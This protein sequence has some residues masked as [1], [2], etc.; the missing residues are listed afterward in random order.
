MPICIDCSFQLDFDG[1]WDELIKVANMLK[2][3]L[4]LFTSLLSIPFHGK[5]QATAETPKFSVEHIDVAMRRFVRA[6][7]PMGSVEQ[8]K[9]TQEIKAGLHRDGWD[10]QVVK[11][12][13]QI[14]NLA[15]ERFGGSDKKAALVKEAEGE[16]IIAISK[17]SERCML[18]IGGHYDT[19]AYREF[20]FVGAND[21]GSSTAAM[22]ELARVV[23]LLRKQEAS[24]KATPAESGR[25]LDCSIALAFFDGE[26]ATLPEWSDGKNLLGIEDNIHG[27]R[28]F[29]ASLE[30]KFEGI[31]YK[32]LPIKAAIV[33]DMIGH[34]NQNLFIT[35]GSHP[36]LT[37]RLLAQKTTTKIAAVNVMIEDDHVPLAQLGVPFLHIIDWTNL[38]EWHKE[39]DTLAITSS[40]H[41]AD[42][43]DMLLR[44]LKQKR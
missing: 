11:F 3:S 25:Y 16:N 9:L 18:I 1:K 7:H 38:E 2:L 34:K 37:Q 20:K 5:A 39:K 33:I 21:G 27:S 43:G 40:R 13:T 41:I 32:G 24:A 10:A 35:N 42:F 23:G 44:F 28:A 36:Q 6:P 30:P 15:Q 26:E 31:T 19:K 17:G 14:P 29:A 4:V 22:Q 8:K 12:R